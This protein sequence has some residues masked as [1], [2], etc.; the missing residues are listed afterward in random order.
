MEN[1]E[2][3]GEEDNVGEMEGEI[4][5]EN[6]GEDETG[7]AEMEVPESNGDL[8]PLEPAS[9]PLRETS[10]KQEPPLLVNVCDCGRAFNTV[11]VSVKQINIHIVSFF[12]Y[13]VRICT[14]VYL[15]DCFC[16]SFVCCKF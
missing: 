2:L 1:G 7:D 13:D 11:P 15:L 16:K 10:T 8:T 12:I 3:E 5:G 9:D 14:F 6:E 4:D